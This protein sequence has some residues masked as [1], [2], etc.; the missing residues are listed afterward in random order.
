MS[1]QHSPAKKAAKK[2]IA[3]QH[4]RKIEKKNSSSI[5]IPHPASGQGEAS[6]KIAERKAESPGATDAGAHGSYEAVRRAM[7]SA[8]AAGL[9]AQDA[10][11]AAVANAQDNT[12]HDAATSGQRDRSSR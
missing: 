6:Q 11:R 2:R 5:P 1:K 3:K 9:A 4:A 10:T 8:H 7:H 12:R